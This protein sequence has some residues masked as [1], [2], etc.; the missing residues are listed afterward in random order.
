[1]ASGLPVV[2]PAS[3]SGAAG[4]VAPDGEQ[5]HDQLPPEDIATH[6]LIC[7]HSVIH[8]VEIWGV[9]TLCWALC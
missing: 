6:S 7:T 8:S 1:M 9:P 2:V 4:E 5:C 3:A